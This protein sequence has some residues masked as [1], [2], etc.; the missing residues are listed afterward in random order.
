MRPPRW[1]RRPLHEYAQRG[2]TMLRKAVLFSAD[3][4]AGHW[5]LFEP[6]MPATPSA[7]AG[8]SWL[9]LAVGTS[10]VSHR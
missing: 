4:D 9:H 3:P 10:G 8:S 1:S 5:P 2:I 7:I 6:W